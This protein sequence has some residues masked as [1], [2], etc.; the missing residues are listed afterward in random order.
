MA[1]E[2][3]TLSEVAARTRV[4]EATLRYWR[5]LGTGGPPSFKVGR[6]VVFRSVDVDAWLEEQRTTDRATA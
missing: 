6:R 4:P 5:S 2:I 1:N 3:E